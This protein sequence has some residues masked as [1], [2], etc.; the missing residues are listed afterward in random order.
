MCS[1]FSGDPPDVRRLFRRE[2]IQRF[3]CVLQM[4]VR[5]GVDIEDPFH[6]EFETAVLLR[7][8]FRERESDKISFQDFHLAEDSGVEEAEQRRIQKC[9][10]G[11]DAHA[12]HGR[13]QDVRAVQEETSRIVI[14]EDRFVRN[15]L[16][17]QFFRS[18]KD[19]FSQTALT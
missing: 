1:G 19:F 13:D 15:E 9:E 7:R 4:A 8:N 3:D 5:T 18:D 14:G 10:N 2:I 16:V 11:F 12:R 6:E 17:N